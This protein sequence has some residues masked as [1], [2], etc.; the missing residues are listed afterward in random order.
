MCL[1]EFK[2]IKVSKNQWGGREVME[3]RFRSFSETKKG[4]TRC[5]LL[6]GAPALCH[7]FLKDA[8]ETNRKSLFRCDV[9]Q[10]RRHLPHL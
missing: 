10:H 2:V 8:G 3:Q 5:L 6:Y 4:C 1:T 7:P 9:L